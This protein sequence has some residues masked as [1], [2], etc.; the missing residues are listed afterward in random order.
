[1]KITDVEIIPIAPKLAERYAH[2]RVDLYGIDCR[3]VYKV[4]TD[5]G[6][7]GYGEQRLRPWASVDQASVEPLIGRN[8]FDYINT[9]LNGGV[10]GALYDVMGKYLEVPAYKLMGQKVRDAVSMAAWTRPAGPE[11]FAREIKRAADQGYSIFKMHSCRYH[12]VIEQTRAACDVAPDGFKIH[13]DFNGTRTLASVIP[14]VHQFEREFPIVGFVE[15]PVERK[16]IEGWRTLRQQSR[17]PIVLHVPQLGGLQEVLHGTADIYMIGGSVGDTLA[18]GMA[19]SKANIQT[20][21]QHGAGTLSKA[22]ALHMAAVLPSASGHSIHLD[23]QYEEDITTERIPVVEGFS[24]VPEGP[25]MGYE[26]D[27]QALA[28]VSAQKIVE[29]PRHV[30]VLHLAGGH[31]FYGRSYIAPEGEEGVVR[32]F[33]SELWEDDGSEEFERVFERVQKEGK[34][35]AN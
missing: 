3:V 10:G 5:N 34:F 28:R 12:D 26:V 16:D 32:G 15:D 35:L 20:I 13:W 2:R 29:K 4:T 9:T 18:R 7:V 23:D 1:M 31:T 30:G 25:G 21:M 17:I 11:E 8:P 6:I 33:T 19:Y 27:E 14:L 22:L 24:P